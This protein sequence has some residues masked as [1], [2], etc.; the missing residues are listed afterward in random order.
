MPGT[1]PLENDRIVPA[2]PEGYRLYE[3]SVHDRSAGHDRF[4]SRSD[5]LFQDLQGDVPVMTAYQK[6]ADSDL[7]GL[8]H[9]GTQV[10]SRIGNC[11]NWR[12][13]DKPVLIADRIKLL[14]ELSIPQTIIVR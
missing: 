4:P 3:N 8:G 6:A 13:K 5:G 2:A 9:P 7:S 14:Q 11:K 1:S 12:L 10:R